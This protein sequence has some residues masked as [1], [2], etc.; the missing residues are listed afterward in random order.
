MN[1]TKAAE[2]KVFD[3]LNETDNAMAMRIGI[4]GGGCSGFNYVFAFA[5]QID[6]GDIIINDTGA[7]VLIDPMSYQYLETATLDYTKD[8]QGER[9]VVSNP[10]AKTQ[11]GCGT[12]FSV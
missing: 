7:V 2:Q 1:L 10:A 4:S 11:C 3:L 8:V 5:E 9:F 6:E 12:S